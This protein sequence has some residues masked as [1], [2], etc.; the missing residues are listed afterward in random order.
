MRETSSFFQPPPSIP[1]PSFS[2]SILRTLERSSSVSEALELLS[3]DM[4]AVAGSFFFVYLLFYCLAAFRPIADERGK[5]EALHFSVF[6]ERGNLLSFSSH[7]SPSETAPPLLAAF[8]SRRRGR[9]DA[10]GPLSGA[11]GVLSRVDALTRRKLKASLVS[12]DGIKKTRPRPRPSF[13]IKNNQKS[14]GGP[15]RHQRSRR[16][17]QRPVP[18][19]V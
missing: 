7:R 4:A 1:I 5:S 9:D 13:Q 8:L 19:K 12:I 11:F 15:A 14:T 6:L 10:V 17:Q 2:R 16:A 18:R 3:E